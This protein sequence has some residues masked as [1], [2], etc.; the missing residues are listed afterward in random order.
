MSEAE[1]TLEHDLRT[2]VEQLPFDVWVRDRE[3][4]CL[5]ANAICR[6]R[7][8]GLVGQLDVDG[9]PDAQVAALW[10]ANNDRALAGEIVRGE[11]RYRIDGA[12]RAVVNILSPIR[13][14]ETIRGT[15][16]ANIDVTEQR[17]A[18][19]KAEALS[20][21]LSSLFAHAP[22]A[23]GVRALRGD[24]LVHVEDNPRAAAM[25]GSTS[26]RLRDTSERE[27]GVNPRLISA[28]IARYRAA[29]ATG[30]PQT[31]ELSFHTPEGER[32]FLGKLAPIPSDREGEE[33]FAVFGEDVT[34]QR[35]LQAGLLRA[36]RLAALGTLAA[37]IGHEIKNPAQ[38]VLTYLTHAVERL[39]ESSR[40]LSSA[41]AE[42]VLADVRA[43]GEGVARIVTLVRDLGRIARPDPPH[44]EP[45][46]V[47][48]VLDS[49]LLLSGGHLRSHARVSRF[50]AHELPKAKADGVRLA[51]VLLNLLTNAVQA[52][53]DRRGNLLVRTRLAEGVVRI[54]IEDDGPG[55]AEELR[56]RLFEPFATTKASAEGSGLGLYVSR[57][58]VE[59]MSGRIGIES[60][61]TG[62]ALAWV[63]LPIAA[64]G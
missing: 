47:R 25:F 4:R 26:E 8:P 33:R 10:R 39:E 52:F 7:W 64:E 43:A 29:V 2:L 3:H 49:V 45:I 9:A 44:L 18:E 38:Y 15:V 48:T 63:E 55:I 22:I 59:S 42:Q 11:V 14:E 56:G 32:T 60:C 1:R 58:I 28:T 30:E 61:P 50:D 12:E 34:T 13:V 51:Q 27:L 35:S 62:G 23:I 24:D 57:Q 41:G 54:E 53:G 36:D 16:G 19:R 40:G 17:V 21:L 5:Y 20:A 46:D 31:F 37:S 6:A